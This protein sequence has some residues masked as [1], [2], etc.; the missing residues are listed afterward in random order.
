MYEIIKPFID[1]SSTSI[2]SLPW[3]VCQAEYVRLWRVMAD[4]QLRLTHQCVQGMFDVM[5]KG[6]EVMDCQAEL[7]ARRTGQ[8]AQQLADA[9]VRSLC[10]ATQARKQERD[11]RILRVAFP[12]ERRCPEETDRRLGT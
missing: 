5:D 9:G 11:R 10:I 7:L 1:P 12:G 3:L 6:V 2:A 4:S 8:V